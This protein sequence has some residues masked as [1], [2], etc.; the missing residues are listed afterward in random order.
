MARLLAGFSNV[1]EVIEKE[2]GAEIKEAGTTPAHV[3]MSWFYATQRDFTYL[4]I[5]GSYTAMPKVFAA[6]LP[7]ALAIA[8]DPAPDYPSVSR[9]RS[10]PKDKMDRVLA[11]LKQLKGRPGLVDAFSTLWDAGF[12]IYAVSN[13]AKEGTK[14]LL[15]TLDDSNSNRKDVFVNGEFDK[16]I[17]SCDE[18]QKA[19]PS[20]EIYARTLELAGADPKQG[21]E[22][23]FIAAHSWDLLPARNAGFKTAYVDFEEIYPCEEIYGKP[24]VFEDGLAKAAKKIVGEI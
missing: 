4:S 2:F 1:I 3:M 22:C 18:V 15:A 21:D 9:V 24:D 12:E 10:F 8:L 7:R 5:S 20:P 17:V 16:Y 11:E 19:K 13:G 23:W 14:A 6:T